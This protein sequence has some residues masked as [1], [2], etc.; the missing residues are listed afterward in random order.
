MFDHA[1]LKALTPFEIDDIT[2]LHLRGTEH[3]EKL[4]A[5]ICDDIME[6]DGDDRWDVLRRRNE[7]RHE[8]ADGLV[9]PYT[10]EVLTHLGIVGTV[11]SVDV[12]NDF[13]EHEDRYINWS[14]V[15]GS[16]F[17]LNARQAL[18]LAYYQALGLLVEWADENAM[19]DEVFD[20]T[21]WLD[22]CGWTGEARNQARQGFHAGWRWAS[23]EDNGTATEDYATAYA[24]GEGHYTNGFDE[25]KNAFE[26]GDYS[27]GVAG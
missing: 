12:A 24:A 25:G 17:E 7:V 3:W 19:P 1:K 10:N 23:A 15:T 27:G 6:A 13:P 20:V 2:G 8:L 21:A 14:N 26:S 16:G 11:W 4:A 18:Y 9:P 5:R 22:K